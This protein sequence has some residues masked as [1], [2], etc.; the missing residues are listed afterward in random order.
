MRYLILIQ[1]IISPL[2]SFFSCQSIENTTTSSTS[3]STSTIYT[4]T[5]TTTIFD[6]NTIKKDNTNDIVILSLN[7]HT[8]Q[9]TNQDAKFNIIVDAIFDLSI[10]LI[11][12]VECGQNKNQPYISGSTSIR[13]DNMAFIIT[14][15]MKS[16]YGVDYY[17]SWDWAHYGW[18][19][20]EEG[21]AVI[22]RY[23]I[24]ESDSTWISTS[25][26]RTDITSRK[27]VFGKTGIP[28]IGAIHLFSVHTH[29]MPTSTDTEHELQVSRIKDFVYS[30][31][32]SGDVSP[33][34]SLVCGDFNCNAANIEPW[35]KPY[36]KMVENGDF[37]DTFLVANPTA[38]NRPQ[39]SKF[40]TVGGTTPG[41]IDYI[42]MKNNAK[43]EV[44][45][46]VITFSAYSLGTV[47]DHYG[48]ITK[49]RLK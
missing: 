39:D 29:W 10:D 31:E 42:F 19:V 22:S 37:I 32:V 12:F 6:I 28:G 47:S 30:K 13:I 34:L 21:M 9:E 14:Q 2:L 41:R 26:S 3:S 40:N 5:T 36:N 20:W 15:K 8:Y 46:S 7:L 18:D 49:L 33:D 48:V 45:S 1:L 23:P 43:F 25:T 16:R 44:V 24:T 27:A 4:P 17:Y 35:I 11:A 38:N